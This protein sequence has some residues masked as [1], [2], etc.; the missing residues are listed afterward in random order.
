MIDRQDDFPDGAAYEG[1]MG[2]WSRVAGEAFVTWLAPAKGLDW[3][4]VGCGNGAFTDVIG[5]LAAP[6][7]L[8]GIDPAK[9]M[10]AYASQRQ[11]G[12]AGASFHIG[13]AQ[14]LP[15]D[16]ASFDAAVMGLVIAF[17]PDPAKALSELARVTRPGGHVATYMWNLPAGGLPLA[18]LFRALAEIGHPGSLPPSAAM[19]TPATLGRLWRE[20]GLADVAT[21]D[22]PITVSFSDF[23]D[24]WASQTL[25]G[26]PQTATLRKLSPEEIQALR[27][28]LR[29]SLPTDAQGRIAYPAL[30]TA[31]RGRRV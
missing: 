1:L 10:V 4:D 28:A 18:P 26:G 17:V 25:P 2:R 16:A 3:L 14:A 30:A 8:T 15:F 31:V 11:G 13:D 24:Y 29:T 7:S 9:A 20:A 27:E 21:T 22:I 5:T 12:C 23:E 19:S 6:R